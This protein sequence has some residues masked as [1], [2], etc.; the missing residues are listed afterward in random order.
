MMRLGKGDSGFNY[1]HIFGMKPFKFQPPFQKEKSKPENEARNC[2]KKRRRKSST[3]Q[4]T[5][6]SPKNGIL[7]MIFLFPRWDML[8]PWRVY[9]SGGFF[10][11]SFGAFDMVHL[12][13]S[14]NTGEKHESNEIK[15]HWYH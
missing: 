13:I 12:K 5:N 8:L 14:S 2:P 15:I 11:L 1:G 4:G 7:K 10:L 6:I 9:F 3:L